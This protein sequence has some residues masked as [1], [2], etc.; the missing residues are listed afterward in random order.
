MKEEFK[1]I[2]KALHSREPTH[3][4]E[5]NGVHR[6]IKKSKAGR[7]HV[8]YTDESGKVFQLVAV[9]KCITKVIPMLSGLVKIG[10]ESLTLD[11]SHL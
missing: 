2:H 3:S 8:F 1:I 7:K 6:I 5:V 11:R 9:A 10:Y 4:V